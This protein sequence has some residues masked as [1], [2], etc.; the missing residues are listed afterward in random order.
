MKSYPQAARE[1]TASR[2]ATR[3]PTG[4]FATWGRG[5]GSSP[6]ESWEDGSGE[7]GILNG[8][9]RNMGT[10]DRDEKEMTA[11]S[12]AFQTDETDVETLP[13]GKQKMSS[14]VYQAVVMHALQL[15]RRLREVFILCD[16]QGRSVP[17]AA[18]LLA[19]TPATAMTRLL[20]ARHQMREVMARLCEQQDPSEDLGTWGRD[21]VLRFPQEP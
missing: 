11:A 9:S 13:I 8:E 20:E 19:I 21:K 3:I 5:E 6:P 1:V 17:E 14:G 10:S 2:A 7:L 4:D 12:A 16:V 18:A 15:E